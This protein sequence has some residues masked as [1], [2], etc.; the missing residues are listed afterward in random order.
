[1]STSRGSGG[2]WA[3]SGQDRT[4]QQLELR[5][6]SEPRAEDNRVEG[7]DSNVNGLTWDLPRAWGSA[8]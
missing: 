6:E 5:K 7:W 8:P 3:G 4:L 1:M 2:P